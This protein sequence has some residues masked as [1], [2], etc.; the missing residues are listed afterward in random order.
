MEGI[1]VVEIP[2]VKM[3]TSGYGTVDELLEK[4]FDEL[5][6]NQ[7]KDLTPH[8]F[9]WYDPERNQMMWYYAITNDNIDTCGFEVIDFEGGLYAAAISIDEDDN[10][11]ERV[12]SGIKQWVKDS[13]CFELDERPNH[14]CM[15]HVITPPQAQ[16]AMGYN[17]LD[18]FVPIKIKA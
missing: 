16:K 4:K 6:F 1:R 2:K 13:G 18:V 14:Y 12:Y 5:I 8:D 7:H 9:M 10:D 17:Q 15:S 11:G 3:V